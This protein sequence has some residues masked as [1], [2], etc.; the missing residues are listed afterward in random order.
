MR[1]FKCKIAIPEFEHFKGSL[2]AFDDE[3]GLI[4]GIEKGRVNQYPLRQGLSGYLWLLLT[5]HKKH[6]KE[7]DKLS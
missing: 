6:F 4:Y 5:W 7:V 3:T 1:Y 2:L